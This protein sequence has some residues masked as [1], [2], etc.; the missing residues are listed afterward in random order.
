MAER[1]GLSVNPVGSRSVAEAMGFKSPYEVDA[2]GRR[3][4]F[5]RRLLSEKVA[6]ER[7][8][9]DF[10]VDRTTLDVLVYTMF[11]DIYA[12]DEGLLAEVALGMKRYT[13]VFFCPVDVFCNP[14]GD[15]ARV[16]D[17]TYHKLC[18]LTLR[19][20][21]DHYRPPAPWQKFFTVSVAGFD[22]RRLMVEKYLGSPQ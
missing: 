12:A 11:H 22:D 14:G 2:A 4:E 21:M 18:D 17:M 6:W 15:A 19:A 1:Y 7:D 20:L 10:V 16:Q 9:E 5:Q 8:H 13:H 3:A